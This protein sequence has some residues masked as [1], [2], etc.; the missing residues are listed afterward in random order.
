MSQK[1][2]FERFIDTFFNV[3]VMIKYLPD[4]LSATVTTLW[5]AAAII[6]AGLVVGLLM[7]CL[8]TANYR[9][10]SFSIVIY[11]DIGRSIP[12]LVVILIFYFGLPGLGIVLS[13]ELVLFLVLGSVLAA[14]AEEVFWAGITCIAQGQW[15]AGTATGLSRNQVLIR[16]VLPQAIRIG[17]PSLVNRALAIS[18]MTALGSVI[19]VKEILAVSSSA[20]S[21]SGSATPLTMAAIAYLAVFLPVVFFCRAIEHRFSWRI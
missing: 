4:L 5:L 15:E 9:W 10:L 8:R 11:A 19:G 20:Q 21:F 2:G 16:I 3:R 18:K 14:F 13:G 6:I 7:A 17:I 1:S 12:P